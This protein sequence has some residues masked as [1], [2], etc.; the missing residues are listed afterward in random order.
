[1]SRTEKSAI[2]LLAA[3]VCSCATMGDRMSDLDP[4]MSKAQVVQK[5]GHPDAQRKSDDEE[6]L[7][8]KDRLVSGWAWDRQDYYVI[9]RKGHVAEYGSGDVR[10]S[11]G[12]SPGPPMGGSELPPAYTEDSTRADSPS[13]TG[14]PALA[15]PASLNP[16]YNAA[17][18]PEYNAAINPKFNASL[19]PEYNA[20]INPKYNAELNPEFNAAINPEHAAD[21]NPNHNPSL[22]PA[23]NVDIV[24]DS[25]R[26]IA[27]V[28]ELDSSFVG[29]LFAATPSC[30]VFIS[31]A[32][33]W[34][35]YAIADGVS[36]MNLFSRDGSWLGYLRDNEDRGFNIFDKDGLWTGFA[37]RTRALSSRSRDHH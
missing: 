4:G 22:N 11:R 33:N 31:P 20:A 5:L 25:K 9:L 26:L 28:F 13:G 1:M 14:S 36:G 24:A 18:N 29:A 15:P 30:W 17:L 35:S 3:L 16:R 10:R 7:I 27:Y 12:K 21:L 32:G 34:R 6:T 2:I 37:V 23:I 19:N 8:Y